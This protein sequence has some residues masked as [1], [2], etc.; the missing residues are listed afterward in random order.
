[1]QAFHQ[2]RTSSGIRW[3]IRKPAIASSIPL[4]LPLMKI[5]GALR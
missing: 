3:I 1:M 2:V 5:S 4:L